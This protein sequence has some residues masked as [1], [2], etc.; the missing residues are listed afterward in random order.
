MSSWTRAAGVSALLSALA[1]LGFAGDAGAHAKA[2]T[3]APGIGSTLQAWR[4]AH[5]PDR[6]GCTPNSCF[7]PAQPENS[8]SGLNYQYSTAQ[9]ENG[10][11]VSYAEAFPNNTLVSVAEADILKTLPGAKLYGTVV[12]TP[13]M[14][15]GSC[16]EWLVASGAVGKELGS[17]DPHGQVGVEFSYLPAQG[18][19]TY[20]PTNVQAAQVVDTADTPRSCPLPSR[21]R[22]R[23]SS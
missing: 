14:G 7:G 1:V 23:Q 13:M 3:T 17:A 22:G 10:R 6:G 2:H 5:H 16:G 20:S 4:T 12:S 21:S 19:Q 18:N 11:M 15:G 8:G 9:F